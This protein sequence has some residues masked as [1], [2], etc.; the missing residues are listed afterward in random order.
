MEN[1]Y[2]LLDKKSGK[3]IAIEKLKSSLVNQTELSS[4]AIA[5]LEELQRQNP[6]KTLEILTEIIN[7]EENGKSNF[8]ADSLGFIVNHF[9]KSTVPNSLRIRFYKLIF[10]KAMEAIRFSESDVDAAYDLLFSVIED[11]S[12]NAPDLLQEA[13]VLMGALRT[14]VSRSIIEENEIYERIENS[15][16]KLST[17]ISEADST[18]NK[19]LK[20]R[21]LMSAARL[22]LEKKKTRLAVD[23]V[24]RT[25]DEKNEHSI[26]WHDQFL[27]EV[28]QQALKE[29]DTGSAR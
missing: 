7:L 3:E 19:S 26:R 25:I 11:I 17:T 21:L 27:D 20:R 24:E 1:A 12:D 28:S 10:R 4:I 13:T 5:L 14:K 9:R 6:A 18:D 29:N 15:Q 2:S 16:D 23:L 22:A 8:S